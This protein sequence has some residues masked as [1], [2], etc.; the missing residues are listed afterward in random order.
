V[1][2]GE[3]NG[4]WFAGNPHGFWYFAEDGGVIAWSGRLVG[5]TLAWERGDMLYRI[6]GDISLERALQIAES[7]P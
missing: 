7:I 2:V 4:Y 3:S 1:K 6:E 5:N